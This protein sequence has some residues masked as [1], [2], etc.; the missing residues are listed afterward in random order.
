M[1]RSSNNPETT[2]QKKDFNH[3][4]LT[5]EET[6]EALRAARETKHYEIR[7]AAY[8]AQ[9]ATPLEYKTY[10]SEEIR[11]S[12]E[13]SG[14][15]IDDNNDHVVDLLCHYFS[16]DERFE[17]EGYKFGRGIVLFGGVGV[18]KTTLMKRLMQNQ[19]QS[20]KVVMCR[21]IEDEF[22][23]EGDKTLTAYSHPQQISANGNAFG[24]KFLGICFDDLGTEPLSKYYGKDTNVMA[25]VILN[26]YDREL[27]FNMT[28]ITTNMTV[29]EIGKR[30]GTRVTDRMREM[31]NLIEFPT[32]AKSRRV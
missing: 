31:F 30:Y 19:I 29:D 7:K 12:L 3:I 11:A 1:T 17:L 24:H 4:V 6:V 14:L 22:S 20:Y 28:H 9:I 21:Q 8:F 15:A 18:G 2:E 25:E 10:T 32:K 27:P 26:R 13:T 5:E 23:Q 16:G